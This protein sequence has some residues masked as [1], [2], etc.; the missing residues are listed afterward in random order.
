MERLPQSPQAQL[1]WLTDQAAIGALLMQYACCVDVGEFDALANLFVEEGVLDLPFGR[2]GKADIASFSTEVLGQFSATHHMISNHAIA[3]DG[4]SATARAYFQATCV[5]S[6]GSPAK[7]SVL[8]GWYDNVYRR[9]PAGWRFVRVSV[10]FIWADGEPLA[11][12]SPTSSDARLQ[13]GAT[14][15]GSSG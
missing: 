11:G 5:A 4:D 6:A 14:L 7:R 12:A 8:G 9:T 2:V 15:P 13:A 1:R 10:T 3:L